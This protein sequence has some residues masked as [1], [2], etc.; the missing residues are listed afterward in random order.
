MSRR[1]VLACCVVFGFGCASEEALT[2]T[3]PTD[4]GY[5]VTEVSVTDTGTAPMDSTPTETGS[6]TGTVMDS[7]A[8][9]TA[10]DAA[11]D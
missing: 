6:D 3:R 5:T 11:A 1:L 8:A 9:E 4:S 2:S 10:T 7:G